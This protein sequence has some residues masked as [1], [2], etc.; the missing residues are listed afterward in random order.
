MGNIEISS[1]DEDF[2]DTDDWYEL[3]DSG[4]ETDLDSK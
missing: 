3:L 4:H 2:M 1:M